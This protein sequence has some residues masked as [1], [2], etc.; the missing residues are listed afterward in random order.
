MEQ[1]GIAFGAG[2]PKQE[3]LHTPQCAA[4][5]SYCPSSFLRILVEPAVAVVVDPITGLLGGD[6]VAPAV[7][8][9]LL[10]PGAGRTPAEPG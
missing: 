3:M 8:G 4:R 5:V 7:D 10:L 2:T 6:T 1:T 9:A